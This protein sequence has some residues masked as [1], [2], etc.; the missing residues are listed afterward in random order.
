MLSPGS[1]RSRNPSLG[2]LLESSRVQGNPP[3]RLWLVPCWDLGLVVVLGMTQDCTLG[4]EVLGSA[5]HAF[6]AGLSEVLRASENKGD[7]AFQVIPHVLSLKG[8]KAG[9]GIHLGLPRKPPCPSRRHFSG[10]IK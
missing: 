2:Q 8:V 3:C 9:S 4:C 6:T 1:H 7:F 5:A 10:K